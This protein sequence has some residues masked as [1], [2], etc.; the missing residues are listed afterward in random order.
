MKKHTRKN[1]LGKMINEPLLLIIFGKS[2]AG[3]NYIGEM[4]A[5]EYGFYFYDADLDLTDEMIS[6]IKEERIFT[7]EM[8]TRYFEQVQREIATLWREHSKLVVTQGLFK[9]RNRHDLRQT[10]PLAQ[11][12]WVDADEGIIVKRVL[13]RDSPVT[14]AYAR[15]INRFFEEPDFDCYRIVNQ[16]E[17]QEVLNK[18]NKILVGL[19]I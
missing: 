12:V 17:Y 16:G 2:G 18:V 1:K 9:N 15:Q 4:I 13:E 6:A 19:V 5:K 14:V 7:D 11:F 3:K 10:F 8:R